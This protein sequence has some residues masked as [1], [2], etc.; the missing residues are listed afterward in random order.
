MQSDIKRFLAYSSIANIGYIV[1]GMGF[2]AYIL[3]HYPDQVGAASLA[4]TGALLH[5]LNHAIGKGLSFLSAG[6][7]I[8]RAGSRDLVD[9]EGMGAKMPLTTASLGAGLLNLAGIPPLSGF[10]SKLFIA[11]A[12]LAVPHDAI[13][14]TTTSIFILNSALAAGYYLWLLQRIAFRRTSGGSGFEE[15]PAMML[16]PMIL[17]ASSCIAI[18]IAL[19]PVLSFIHEA[20]G[21]I[22]G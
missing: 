4:L 18:T 1:V 20:I 15:V 11:S 8:V 14:L 3:N 5:I 2:A 12:G 22:L 10:W 17:L 13:L 6:C 16:T 9:L 7:Y 21:V 19:A